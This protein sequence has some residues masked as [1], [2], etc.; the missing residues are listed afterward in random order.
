MTEKQIRLSDESVLKAT[1][2]TWA[3]WRKLL[4]AQEAQKLTHQEIVKLLRDKFKLSKGW[5]QQM[6][7]N[8]YEKMIGRRVTGSSTGAG[9]MMGAQATFPFDTKAAWRFL[10]SPKA[11]RVWLGC[12]VKPRKGKTYKAKNGTTG[13]FRIVT[14]TVNLRLS[15]QPKTWSK[16][17]TL[18]VRVYPKGQQ[19]V[20]GF[21]MEN[22]PGLKERLQMK[23]Y[24][25]AI[26]VQLKKVAS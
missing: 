24:W 21:H 16:P 5:W 7:T 23:E 22:L 4:D 19:S 18:Q 25:A 15:Y 10:A 1:G 8:T 20:I 9:F 3:Q 11:M 12:A 26:L 14:P 17:A 13:M 6:V 2:K